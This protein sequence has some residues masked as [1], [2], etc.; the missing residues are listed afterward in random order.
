MQMQRIKSRIKEITKRRKKRIWNETCKNRCKEPAKSLAR[1]HYCNEQ[2][3]KP[4]DVPK[5]SS[6]GADEL[7]LGPILLN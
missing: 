2:S 6:A 4:S 3:K 5:Y 7:S 1:G